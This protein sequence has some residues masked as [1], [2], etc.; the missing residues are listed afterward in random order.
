MIMIITLY[1]PWVPTAKPPF[2]TSNFAP[3]G[4]SPGSAGNTAPVAPA[5][6]PATMAYT[7]QLLEE[8]AGNGR[9][10]CIVRECHRYLCDSIFILCIYLYS[11][12]K[13]SNST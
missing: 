10:M 4:A 13:S 8:E 11:N 5:V 12:N 6:F 9:S 7:L 2:F 1:F 3:G